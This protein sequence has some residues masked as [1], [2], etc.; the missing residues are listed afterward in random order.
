M[1]GH[2]GTMTCQMLTY[3]R[4]LATMNK[5]GSVV[6]YLSPGG[7]R[8]SARSPVSGKLACS[9]VE[10]MHSPKNHNVVPEVLLR[11]LIDSGASR[12]IL[13]ENVVRNNC[14][15]LAGGVRPYEG[16][17]FST[18]NGFV[19]P[20]SS[21]MLWVRQLRATTE[22]VIMKNCLPVLSLGALVNEQRYEFRWK[23]D[24]MPYL[25]HTGNK[26]KVVLEV[27][28]NTPMLPRGIDLATKKPMLPSCRLVKARD[29]PSHIVRPVKGDR[30]TRKRK[31]AGA[32]GRDAPSASSGSACSDADD[33][34]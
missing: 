6:H 29:S 28:M 4:M 10:V 27:E 21:V 22:C 19:T 32:S 16:R 33:T 3:S 31:H 7:A 12:H 13:P 15:L 20:E 23:P 18:A 8:P 14:G 2:D 26:S 11:W 1:S 5:H 17:A 24:E 25:L 9:L 30:R 34:Q